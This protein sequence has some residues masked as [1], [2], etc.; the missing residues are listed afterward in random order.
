MCVFLVFW[1]FCV[2]FAQVV[3]CCVFLVGMAARGSSAADNAERGQER[4]RAAARRQSEAER[5]ERTGGA[6]TVSEKDREE[7]H[8]QKDSVMR[9]GQ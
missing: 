8:S 1:L 6:E 2:L 4:S 9:D 5:R 3:L 7:R